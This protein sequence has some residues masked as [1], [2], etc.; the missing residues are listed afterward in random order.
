MTRSAKICHTV[1]VHKTGGGAFGNG[2][3]SDVTGSQKQAWGGSLGGGRAAMI[4]VS[5]NRTGKLSSMLETTAM[6]LASKSR[7]GRSPLWRELQQ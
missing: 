2:D 1:T 5:K 3:V 7:L 4:P 6:A